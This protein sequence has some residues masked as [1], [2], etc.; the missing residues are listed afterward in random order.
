MIMDAHAHPHSYN[1]LRRLWLF[2]YFPPPA[3]PF[4]DVSVA[5]HSVGEATAAFDVGFS[6]TAKFRSLATLILVDVF[7]VRNPWVIRSVCHTLYPLGLGY[8]GG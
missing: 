4:E 8:G 1:R 2:T 7:L 3:Y 6:C 5:S